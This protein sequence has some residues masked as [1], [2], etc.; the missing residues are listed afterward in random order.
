[1]LHCSFCSRSQHE[2]SKLI[3]GPA[4]FICEGCVS[5]IAALESG[6]PQDSAISKVELAS[7]RHCGF[8]G[9]DYVRHGAPGPGEAPS[10]PL[11]AAA[12][13]RICRNCVQLCVDIIKETR[14]GAER[15]RRADSG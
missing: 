5:A 4:L 15:L 8:C 11:Y 13:A 3:A 12:D 10:T 14:P 9:R 6:E 1:L 2:E 7:G